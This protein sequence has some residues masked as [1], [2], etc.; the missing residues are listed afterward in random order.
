MK[1]WEV[2]VTD[3]SKA[4]SWDYASNYFPRGFYYKRDAVACQKRAESL[5]VKTELKDLRDLRK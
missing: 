5:G 1:N 4:K 2:N 3:Y